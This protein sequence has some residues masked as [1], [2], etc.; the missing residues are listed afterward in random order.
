MK[1][2]QINNGD[3]FNF[4]TVIKETESQRIDGLRPKRMF[5]CE[6]ICGRRVGVRLDSLRNN[7]KS[8]CGCQLPISIVKTGNSVKKHGYAKHPLYGVW[9][10]IKRR[11]Y[12]VLDINYHR[13][14]G[15]GIK[16]SNEWYIDAG[17]FIK[18]GIENDYKEGLELDRIDNDGGYFPEN[19]RWATS[20][21]NNNNK[22]NNKKYLY[23]GRW[24]TLPQISRIH[25]TVGFPTLYRRIH[26]NK[27]SIEEALSIPLHGE[28]SKNRKL[29]C[30][31][32]VIDMLS[33]NNSALP[34][35][36]LAKKFNISQTTVWRIKTGQYIFGQVL[37]NRKKAA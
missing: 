10:N 34:W 29:R 14:G 20:E 5:I 24:L 17:V 37:N 36:E 26:I 3:K 6:C 25:G 33:I 12:S 21:I 30:K 31:V 9:K 23:D 2:L 7:K 15:R 28:C 27:L 8:S 13:Y 32:R 19:C 16:M 35:G 22:R 18:W 4:L 11:C 1:G